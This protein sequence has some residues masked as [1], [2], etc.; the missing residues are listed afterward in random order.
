MID[1][2]R[3]RYIAPLETTMQRIMA[4]FLP[5]EDGFGLMLR[6]VMGWVDTD[7]NAY[8]HNTGK[9]LRPMLMLVVTEA[10]GGTVQPALPAAAAVEFLHNFSLIHDDIQDNSSLRHGRPTAWRVW[11]EANAINAGDAMF[12]LAYSALESLNRAD[13]GRDSDSTAPLSV[14]ADTVLQIWRLFNRTNLELTRGQHLDMRF[15]RE[16]EVTVDAYLS[17]I[18]GKSAALIAASAYMGAIIATHDTRT[19]QQFY[20]FGHNAGIAFQIHDDILGIWGDEAV[21]GKSVSTDILSRKKSLPVL[22]ALRQSTEMQQLYMQ[23]D[24]NDDDVRQTMTLLDK[25]EARQYAE[26]IRQEYYSHALQA[27]DQPSVSSLSADG[28][29]MLVGLVDYLLERNH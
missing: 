24:F 27:L 21:T 18:G 19:A 12:T 1:K 4:D 14:P 3:Q 28:R 9:R 23:V 7:D 20:E 26:G 2:L 29:A 5:D 22:Y 13:S 15:E 17:M 11:G 6:Y 8:A 16:P 10:L 25:A